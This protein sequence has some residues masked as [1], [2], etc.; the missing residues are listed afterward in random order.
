MQDPAPLIEQLAVGPCLFVAA[1]GMYYT[2]SDGRQVLDGT[3]GLWCSNAGHKRPKIVEAVQ[4]Q[5]AELDYA[6]TFQMGHP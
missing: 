5:V 6:P 1:D 3:A 4:A 2:T